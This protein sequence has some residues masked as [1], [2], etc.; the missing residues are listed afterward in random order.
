MPAVTTKFVHVA[1]DPGEQ[2]AF[3]RYLGAGSQ[4]CVNLVDRKRDGVIVVLKEAD[5]TTMNATNFERAC[6]EVVNLALGTNHGNIVRF[7]EAWVSVTD[8]VDRR[9]LAAF[10]I[11]VVPADHQ[12]DGA[13]EWRTAPEILKLSKGASRK[14]KLYI[15][16]DYADGGTL[17]NQIKRARECSAPLSEP[18]IVLWLGH[19]ALGLMHLHSR[20]ILHRDLKT[21]NIFL[22]PQGCIKIGDFGISKLMIDSDDGLAHT[23][24]GT[25]LYMSPEIL[26]GE[27][28]GYASDV[29]GLGCVLVEM[30]TLEYAFKAENFGQLYVNIEN[31]RLA[32]TLPPNFSQPLRELVPRML[33]RNV[34]ERIKLPELLSLPFVRATITQWLAGVMSAAAQSKAALHEPP[35]PPKAAPMRAA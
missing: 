25:P 21:A 17:G 10:R 7:H 2:Y 29:W 31:V 1:E 15:V 8:G 28:Y 33:T 19:M 24:T 6:S 16:M 12:D 27:A 13:L 22:T 5:T 9:H 26:R 3:R 18:K 11:L 35:P 23:T 34:S 14:I 30:M 32:N 20:G 4:G